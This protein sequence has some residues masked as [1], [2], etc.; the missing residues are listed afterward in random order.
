MTPMQ[1]VSDSSAGTVLIWHSSETLTPQQDISLQARRPTEY[2]LSNHV[3][4]PCLRRQF[5]RLIHLCDRKHFLMFRRNFSSSISFPSSQG[6]HEGTLNNLPPSFQVLAGR[7]FPLLLLLQ[8]LFPQTFHHSCPFLKCLH[9]S[10]N[11]TVSRKSH[12]H[13]PQERG[14]IQMGPV[15]RCLLAQ[16]LCASSSTCSQLPYGV[17]W[18]GQACPHSWPY[19]CC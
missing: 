4:T 13:C 14:L 15:S 8:G 10:G 9:I 1:W 18:Q 7:Q 17:Q 16:D 5:P 11:F 3:L 19:L 2:V 12:K 6:N